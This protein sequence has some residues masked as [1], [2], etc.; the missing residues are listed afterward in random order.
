MEHIKNLVLGL[1][2][3]VVVVLGISG[4]FYVVT[5]HPYISLA[6]IILCLAYGFGWL[7][8]EEIN[9]R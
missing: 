1:G 4:F 3:V 8:R 6:L 9:Y 7:I 2:I 5:H